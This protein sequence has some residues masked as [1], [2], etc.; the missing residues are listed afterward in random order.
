MREMNP[1]EKWRKNQ[2]ERQK[3]RHKDRDPRDRPA[4]HASFDE[5][6]REKQ[7]QPRAPIIVKV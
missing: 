5:P 3:K 6:K 7:V 2:K 1:V 4:G